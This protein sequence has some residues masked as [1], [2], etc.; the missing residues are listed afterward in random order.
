MADQK[1]DYKQKSIGAHSLKPETLMM[2]YGYAPHLSE[3]AVKPPVFLTSTFAFES[4]EAG[5]EFFNI[6]SGR[7]TAPEGHNGGLIYSRFNHPNVEIVEDRLALLEETETSVVFSSGMGAISSTLLTYLRPGDVILHSTPLYGGTETLIRKFLPEFGVKTLAFPA[8]SSQAH[9]MEIIKQA[10]QMGRLG[11]VYF[12]TPANP[13]NEMVDFQAIT[14]AVDAFEK[15]SGIRP[16]LVCDNTM[17]GPVFQKAVPNGADIALYS[18]TKYVG[19]HSDLVAGAVCGKKSA[20]NPIR[21][22][23]SALGLNL[24][25]HTSWMISRSLETLTIRMERAAASGIAVAQWLSDNPYIALKVLHPE[26]IEDADYQAVYRRQCTGP[27]STFS[28]VADADKHTMFKFINALSLFKSAVSLGGSESLVCHPASTT[29]SGVSKD[30]R[31]AVGVCDGLVR[32]SIG[33]E[34]PDDLIA[35]LDNAM[36]EAFGQQQNET[37]PLAKAS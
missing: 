12:E 1:K 23:R 15:E 8:G 10:Q 16:V 26:F 32:L 14:Q 11:M 13:T 19:G 5:E 3:G 29:H 28:F 22:T 33:L 2:S 4:A 27:G 6:V 7:K 37:T 18:L 35:D 21:S 17:L 20:L 9:I 34:H 24:D 25:P 31:D 36:R 30:V